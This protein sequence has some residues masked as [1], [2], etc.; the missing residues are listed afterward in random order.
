MTELWV[1]RTGTHRYTGQSSRGAEVLEM[2]ASSALIAAMLGISP[3]A[4]A[5]HV[6]EPLAAEELVEPTD[7]LVEFFAIARAGRGAI[8]DVDRE[9]VG[10]VDRL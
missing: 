9:H 2:A 8:V 1:E 4:G 10:D 3:T 7:P 6:G 5:V